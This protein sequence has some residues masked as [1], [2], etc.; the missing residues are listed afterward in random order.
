MARFGYKKLNS[1]NPLTS[2]KTMR[3]VCENYKIY[4]NSYQAKNGVLPTEYTQ[5]DY[6]QSS[7]TQYIDT[8]V[9]PTATLSAE[10]TIQLN[11]AAGD[12]KLF[13]S[14]A[15]ISAGINLGAISGY[16]RVGN[17][18]WYSSLVSTTTNITTIKVADINNN[19][20]WYANGELIYEN[21][22]SIALNSSIFLMGIRYNGAYFSASALKLFSCKIWDN[23][24]LVRDFIP[25][26]RNSDSVLGLYDL[27]SETFFT[28]AGSGTFI[29]GTE[30]FPNP[31]NPIDV[32]TLGV[33]TTK[34][35]FDI[36]TTAVVNN[37][38]V[39]E[40]TYGTIE[41]GVYTNEMSYYNIGTHLRV[42][43]GTI[44]GGNTYTLSAYVLSP[45]TQSIY[46]GV[47]NT[48]G[49]RTNVYQ[50]VTANVLTHMTFTVVVPVGYE[51][52]Q[53]IQ[54][55][56][57]TSV[58]STA[59]NIVFSNI[60]LEYGSSATE[61]ESYH[62]YKI[63]AETTADASGKNLPEKITT[64]IYINEP[65]RKVGTVADYIDYKQGKVIRNVGKYVFTG[66]ETFNTYTY[67]GLLGARADVLIAGQYLRVNGLCTHESRIGDVYATF[68]SYMWLGV[69]NNY[70]FWVGVLDELGFTTVEEFKTWLAE[71]YANGTPV[72]IYY[73]LLTPTEE[74]ITLP[75]IP[76]FWETTVID[77]GDS[78]G[79]KASQVSAE[80]WNAN[81]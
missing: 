69:N 79:L 33:L 30:A 58:N 22:P 14:F 36:Q 28:N 77:V 11:T 19:Y 78:N 44:I 67:S 75:Q 1:T 64:N 27:V 2:P 24:V 21:L 32:E 47:K 54:L 71:Q 74:T 38:D 66:N 35:L 6:I 4:G 57:S 76:T 43:Q 15:G 80:L 10:L 59:L 3:G 53:Y 29:I 50:S 9:N 5:L 20:N 61:Y 17:G 40:P 16:W 34:N 60:Q 62:K 7:G 8:G 49:T 42:P 52:Y 72:T 70:M 41:N 37:A 55:Q 18:Q 31:Q 48:S 13:G 56:G 81:Y 23:N 46:F 39:E 73:Q 45:T 68:G 51:Y 25:A 63:T 12:Q 65:L 26:K